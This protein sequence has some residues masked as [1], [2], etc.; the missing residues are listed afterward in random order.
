MRLRTLVGAL[1][2][3]RA[4]TLADDR[5]RYRLVYVGTISAVTL[6]VI[7]QQADGWPLTTARLLVV[8][9]GAVLTI[10]CALPPARRFMS[11]FGG[12]A[13]M[14]ALGGAVAVT[15]GPSSPLHVGWS[16]LVVY[17]ALFYGR[18]RFRASLL[19]VAALAA[20]P[21]AYGRVWPDT[22]A[23]VGATL[24][25]MIGVTVHS[26]IHRIRELAE[27]D[28][29]TGLFNHGMFW[30]VAG[31]EHARTLRAGVPYAVL[32]IDADHFKR[33]ND[34][35][36]HRAGDRVLQRMATVVREQL[37]DGDL[38]ARYGG[39]EIAVLLPDC[40]ADVAVQVAE[41]IRSAV[42]GADFR[43]PVTVS[44]GV[45][46]WVEP[47]TVEEVVERAD[48]ALYDAKAAGRNRVALAGP[49]G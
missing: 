43:T 11:R 10:A 30:H 4:A 45:S 8:A 48:A 28:P 5:D 13:S 23:L 44:V 2:D 14:V 39:E 49:P 6:P 24:V 41:R 38:V 16:A 26:F 42:A 3:A 1:T 36:G 21:L 37:R 17:A 9:Y 15:G 20:L 19:A 18:R 25:G 40:T 12:V 27:T 22:A 32:V 34:T 31:L 29:L 7:A 46:V 47:C 35:L 33:V